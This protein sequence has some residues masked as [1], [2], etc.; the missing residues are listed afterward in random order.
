MWHKEKFAEH[1]PEEKPQNWIPVPAYE[2]D[3]DP[4]WLILTGRQYVYLM[5]H[6]AIE[7]YG[8]VDRRLV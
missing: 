1:Y 8:L 7:K 5:D 2:G 3:E 4:A 6:V